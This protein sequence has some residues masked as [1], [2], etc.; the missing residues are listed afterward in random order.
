M[1]VL[2][3]RATSPVATPWPSSARGRLVAERVI[4]QRGHERDAGAEARR[5][6]GLVAALAAV[7]A[8]ERPAQH[9]LPRGGQPIRA[10]DEVDVDRADDD[11]PAAH[12]VPRATAARSAVAARVTTP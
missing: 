4:P 9:G 2:A 12:R 7:E 1:G 5:R 11:D 10:H 6:D 3:R 8:A